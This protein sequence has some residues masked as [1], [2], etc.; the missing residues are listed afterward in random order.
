MELIRLSETQ[1]LPYFDC[2]DQDLNDFLLED[3]LSFLKGR[4]ANTFLLKDGDNIV[5]YFCLLNDKINQKDLTNSQWKKI[6][7]RFSRQKRFSS[8]PAIKIGRFAVAT[9]YHGQNIGSKL[10]NIIKDMLYTHQ[11]FSAFRFITVDAYLSAVS[12][13]EKNNFVQ[14]TEKEEKD[15]TR[16]MYFD[17]NEFV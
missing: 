11:N 2:G 9:A 8:Y 17:M 13:Y 5:A 14:L 10:I 12:F 6:K 3:A 7:E 1:D 16:L 4:I 15:H